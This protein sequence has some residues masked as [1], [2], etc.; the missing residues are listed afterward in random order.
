[1][2]ERAR[3]QLAQRTTSLSIL[4]VEQ[5]IASVRAL[6]SLIKGRKGMGRLAYLMAYAA[7]G[8]FCLAPDVLAD[9]TAAQRLTWTSGF[10]DSPDIAADSSGNIHVVWYDDTPGNLEVYH[11][12]STDGGTTW[13]AV[14]RISETV[15]WSEFPVLTVDSNNT[16]H[17]V[18]ND[19]TPDNLEIYYGRSTDGGVAWDAAK[20]LTWNSGGSCVPAIAAGPDDTV[21]IVWYDDTPGNFEIYYKKGK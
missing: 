8:L 1:M 17:V 12:K 7:V 5:R 16:L 13:R 21:H 6:G 10:S 15:G 19:D 9:W 2:R 20:R 18:W 11:K 3:I 14:K 4:L